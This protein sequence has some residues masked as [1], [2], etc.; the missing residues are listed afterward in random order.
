MAA[1]RYMGRTV[2]AVPRLHVTAKN[3]TLL[4]YERHFPPY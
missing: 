2:A 3:W 1:R 4:E